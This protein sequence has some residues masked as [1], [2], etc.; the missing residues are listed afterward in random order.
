MLFRM[1]RS[2]LARLHINAEDLGLHPEPREIV[3][4]S[5]VVNEDDDTIPDGKNVISTPQE[6]YNRPSLRAGDTL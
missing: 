4:L 6:E 1:V 2:I 3:T 5:D